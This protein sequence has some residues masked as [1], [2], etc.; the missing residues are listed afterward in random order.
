MGTIGELPGGIKVAMNEND[1]NP[2]HVH[3]YC[4]EG[5][6]KLYLA[7]YTVKVHYG[8]A[9]K[10][11]KA[12]KAALDW[13]REYEAELAEMWRECQSGGKVHRIN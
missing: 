5:V 1:H 8:S 7:T 3:M 12:I 13:L 11:R 4:P 9:V 2:P 6:F 10:A